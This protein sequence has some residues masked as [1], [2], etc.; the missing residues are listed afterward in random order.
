MTLRLRRSGFDTPTSLAVTVRYAAP[1]SPLVSSRPRL[2][3]RVSPAPRSCIAPSSLSRSRP[4]SSALVAA[5]AHALSPL[6]RSPSSRRPRA[7]L[8][9]GL[10]G[11]SRH[12]TAP[13]ALHFAAW[14]L[15][16]SAAQQLVSSAA[17]L[18]G[19]PVLQ[20][21]SSSAAAQLRVSD[22]PALSSFALTRQLAPL[23]V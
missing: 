18:S 22:I 14:S 1:A 9:L 20:L 4:L 11:C 17:A 7:R 13:L 6:S 15:D 3:L 16:G 8:A 5:V 19:S 10:D 21:S 23:P 12:G 2:P